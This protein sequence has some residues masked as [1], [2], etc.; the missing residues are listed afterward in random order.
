MRH[1][2][3][4]RPSR[5]LPHKAVQ[6]G[7]GARLEALVAL[8]PSTLTAYDAFLMAASSSALL[9]RPTTATDCSLAYSFSAA[10]VHL[11]LG[12]AVGVA[13]AAVRE[14]ER[15]RVR[16]TEREPERERALD[17]VFF[18]FL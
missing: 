2:Q 18:A 6:V 1:Q 15:D 13:V 16:E 8:S 5:E 10:M 3:R 11:A 17:G 7:G 12:V 14:P 4:R 9:R